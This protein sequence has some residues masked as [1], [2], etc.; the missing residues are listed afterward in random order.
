MVA[1]VA[2]VVK[3]TPQ[4]SRGGDS[5]RVSC[6]IDTNHGITG[7][8]RSL[9][10]GYMEQQIH[11]SVTLLPL[12]K[13]VKDTL[14]YNF[15]TVHEMLPHNLAKSRLAEILGMRLESSLV[16]IIPTKIK[17]NYKTKQRPL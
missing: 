17:N 16:G 14:H 3:N 2:K 13:V 15:T 4:R 7:E 10:S 6:R 1:Q 9:M 5:S 8:S 11:T 12:I